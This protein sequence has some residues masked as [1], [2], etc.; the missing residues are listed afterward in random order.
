[1]QILRYTRRMLAFFGCLSDERIFRFE[2]LH[3]FTALII[4]I[5]LILLEVSSG[6]YVVKSLQIG[7]IENSLYGA[8]QVSA[9]I[10][11][12]GSFGTI[13]YHKENFRQVIDGFQ[14]ISDKCNCI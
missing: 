2:F 1:M 7:D 8:L 9:L 12:F 4:L 5:I 10:L 6:I 13:M 3:T 14:Q 11:L